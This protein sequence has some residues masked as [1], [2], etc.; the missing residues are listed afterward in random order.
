MSRREYR[1]DALWVGMA[2]VPMSYSYIGRRIPD[3]TRRLTGVNIPPHF[4]RDAAATPLVRTSPQAA[5][6]IA[7]VLGHADHRTA[8]RHYIQAGSI[9]AGRD[10]ADM[11]RW[12]RRQR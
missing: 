5:R 1:H 10:Y 4:F 12:L 3:I 2:G 8:E 11:L 6:V 9:E 7:P